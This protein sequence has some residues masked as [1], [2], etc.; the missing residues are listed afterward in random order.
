[1]RIG[2]APRG[3]LSAITSRQPASSGPGASRGKRPTVVI[4]GPL[5]PPLHGQ[6]KT[7]AEMIERIR[8]VYETRVVDLSPGRLKRGL[9]Y[10]GRKLWR[11]LRATLVVLA[12]MGS[13][14]RLYVSLD[15]GWGL[16]YAI[17]LQALARV[18]RYQLFLKHHSFSYIEHP[19]S[20]MKGIVC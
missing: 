10:H 12:A 20:L 19:F 15:A 18:S 6:S 16:L 13:Q 8:G 1:M 7:T 9:R 4:V 2:I 11:V 14:P 5:P 3:R 17:G